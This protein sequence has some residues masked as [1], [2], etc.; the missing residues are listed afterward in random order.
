MEF[1][2]LGPFWALADCPKAGQNQNGK[3]TN[4]NLLGSSSG[5]SYG[6]KN[7]KI[8]QSAAHWAMADEKRCQSTNSTHHIS[9]QK[10]SVSGRWAKVT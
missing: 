7:R 1:F 10:P 9:A 3:Q 2:S 8:P 4:I 5:N 6:G